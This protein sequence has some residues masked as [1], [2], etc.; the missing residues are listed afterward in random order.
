MILQGTIV[1]HLKLNIHVLIIIAYRMHLLD[2]LF[3]I[4]LAPASL[5][6]V[7]QHLPAK[8]NRPK[9]LVMVSKVN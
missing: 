6:V 8:K 3:Y 9:I 7:K 2:V 5:Q 1:L 4:L